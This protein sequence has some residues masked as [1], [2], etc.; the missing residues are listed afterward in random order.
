M[1]AAQAPAV[2]ANAGAPPRA[3]GNRLPRVGV[4]LDPRREPSKW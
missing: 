1:K 2:L 3:E 4:A